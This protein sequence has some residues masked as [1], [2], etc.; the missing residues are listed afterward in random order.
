MTEPNFNPADNQPLTVSQPEPEKIL[1]AWQSPSRI[2]HKH[3]KDFYTSIGTILFLVCIILLFLKQFVLILAIISFGFFVYVLDNVK[4]DT[5]S[6]QIT[7]KGIFTNN[8]LFYYPQ[9]GRF[10]I[11]KEH[12]QSILYL[13]NLIGFPPRLFLLLN[14]Q[15]SEKIEQTL[16]KY[17]VMQKPELTQVEI[18]SRWLSEKIT[19]E[20]PPKSPS[21][22]SAK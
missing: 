20:K 11:Q 8:K 17:L 10:W 6:H 9:L 18:W 19:L 1:L 3:S 14:D 16:K 7:N 2:Y 15:D 22:S 13:E 21:S 5:L 12:G 4:P